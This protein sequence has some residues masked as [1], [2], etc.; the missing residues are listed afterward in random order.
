MVIQIAGPDLTNACGLTNDIVEAFIKLS[1]VNTLSSDP[2]W[3]ITS[4]EDGPAVNNVQSSLVTIEELDVF[5][6][7]N[8]GTSSPSPSP[9]NGVENLELYPGSVV[10]NFV[11]YMSPLSVNLAM[12]SYVEYIQSQ[13]IV[14]MM[15]AE[16]FEDIEWTSMRLSPQLLDSRSEEVAEQTS[17]SLIS[18]FSALAGAA[19][20]L[21]A[22]V[23]IFVV[24]DGVTGVLSIIRGT[25]VVPLQ[26]PQGAALVGDEL[27]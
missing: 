4:V 25:G 26:P 5:T 12:G 21:A 7:V 20:A 6:E 8:D 2:M 15:K 14:Q 11:A 13:N 23:A 16:G 10:F 3:F 27:V 24:K 9:S 18:G 1:A 17:N 19:L 22:V